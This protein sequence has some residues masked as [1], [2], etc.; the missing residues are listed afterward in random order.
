LSANGPIATIAKPRKKIL[1]RALTMKQLI[2]NQSSPTSQG[3]TRSDLVVCLAGVVLL[4]GLGASALSN[5]RDNS[6]RMVC[7]SN[8][9]QMGLAEGM[10]ASDNRDYLAYCN[11]DGGTSG[12]PTGWLYGVVG[13]SIPDPLIA[14][15]VFNPQN[16]W[17]NGLW[18]PYVQNQ[19]YYL[20]PAD[21][22]SAD[23]Y[24]L[25]SAGGRNNHL[26][27]YVMNGAP[28]A[29]AGGTTTCK[30]SDV[31][32]PGCLLMWTPNENSLGSNN[33]GAFEYND[34]AN[35]PQAPPSGGEEIATLHC[36]N[37]D[38]ALALGGNVTFVSE[39][40]FIA[41]SNSKGAGPGGKGLLWWSPFSAN[42][43]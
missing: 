21:I 14:P 3:F 20:C 4:S 24:E 27:S 9:R 15:Y 17:T 23:L 25:P 42:G 43:H 8:L 41:T 32:S 37:G 26:S 34:G 40:V 7:A 1:P 19:N 35:I 28:S 18:W 16:A 11:W 38:D 31:W 22:Q 5:S 2:C 10:Y 36:N 39:T 30:V 13:N 6:S 33:P 12:G 29:F